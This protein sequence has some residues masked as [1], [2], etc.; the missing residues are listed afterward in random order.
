MTWINKD[1][2]LCTH[3]CTGNIILG[4]WN[5]PEC[6]Q[7]ILG[8][9][10][11]HFVIDLLIIAGIKGHRWFSVI[12]RGRQGSFT[13]NIHNLHLTENQSKHV[14]NCISY[15]CNFKWLLS[16]Q[17]FHFLQFMQTLRLRITSKR[18][19]DVVK[20]NVVQREPIISKNQKATSNNNCKN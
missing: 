8:T 7:G 5:F 12:S 3:A 2:L 19:E 10:I 16:H 14:Q 4:L 15:K 6:A 18:Y 13:S 20:R 9:L 11:L 1:F 17:P